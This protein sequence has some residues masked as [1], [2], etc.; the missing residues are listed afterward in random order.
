MVDAE[1]EYDKQFF[2][3]FANQNT[4]L[5]TDAP[6]GIEL[7]KLEMKRKVILFG[8]LLGALMVCSSC[9]KAREC[10]CRLTWTNP[11]YSVA[12]SE[13]LTWPVNAGEPCSKAAEA[14]SEPGYYTYT[15]SEQ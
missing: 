7:G 3:S 8:I 10:N 13:Y 11:N 5:K 15:C 2:C 9:S 6:D 14:L 12:A 1:N 4:I